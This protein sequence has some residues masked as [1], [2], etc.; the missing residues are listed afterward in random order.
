MKKIL[1]NVPNL[2]RQGN[3]EED[4]LFCACM[5]A[6]MQFLKEDPAYEFVHFTSVSGSFFKIVWY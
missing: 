5:R 1:K 6:S 3:V 4:F 2:N